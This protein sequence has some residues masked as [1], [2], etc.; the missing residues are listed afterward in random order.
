MKSYGQFCPVA[1]AAELFCE[2][3]TPLIVRDLAFGASRFSELQRGVPLMSPTLLSRRL[4]Q[5]VAE[6]VVERR[7]SATGKSWTYHLT[8]AGVEFVPLVETLGVWGQRWSRR[9]LA[10]GEIDLGLLL[11]TLERSVKANAFGKERSVIHLHFSDQPSGKDRW[12]F[13][14]HKDECELCLEDPGYDVDL[15]LTCNLPDMIYLVRGDLTLTT[16][17]STDRLD[18]MGTSPAKKKLADWLNLS[19]LSQIKSNLPE[20]AAV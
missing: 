10:E 3:W 2:R 6:G 7:R 17:M 8:P 9:Q 1:K 14:N 12:W 20:A 18:V 4:K 11:W 16:A 19:P 5:L 13:V 15:Y